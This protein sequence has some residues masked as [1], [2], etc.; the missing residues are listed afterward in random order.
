MHMGEV[1][2]KLKTWAAANAHTP[3]HTNTHALPCHSALSPTSPMEHRGADML[4]GLVVCKLAVFMG[5]FDIM[6]PNYIC[7][8]SPEVPSNLSP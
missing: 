4:T 7:L 6:Q 1:E 2:G 3:A 5:H 8:T